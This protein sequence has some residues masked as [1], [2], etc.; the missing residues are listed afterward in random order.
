MANTSMESKSFFANLFDFSFT[1]FITLRFMKWIYAILVGLILLLGFIFF[2]TGL[3]Q[4]EA[5]GIFFA[6]IVVPVATLF[7]LIFARVS[8]EMVALF[9]R[10]GENTSQIASSLRGSTPP[11]PP[12]GWGPPGAYQ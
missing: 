2:M 8:L 1:S 10:I 4:G 9:F 11:A 7:Y 3:V 6:F 12:S 5:S